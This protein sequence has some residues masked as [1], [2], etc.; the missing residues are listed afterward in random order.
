[1]RQI[2]PTPLKAHYGLHGGFVPGTG[3]MPNVCGYL[4]NPN[5]F[6]GLGGGSTF[7]MVDPEREL[8]VVFLS[9]GFIEGLPCLIRA[10]EV[11]RFGAGSVRIIGSSEIWKK[12]FGLWKLDFKL[13]FSSIL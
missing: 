9:A 7:Y 6:A 13:L 2:A 8:T 4:A 11:K 12:Q 3:H 5:A 10:S 1:M